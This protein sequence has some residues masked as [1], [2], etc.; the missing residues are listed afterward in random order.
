MENGVFNGETINFGSFSSSRHIDINEEE[1]YYNIGGTSNSLKSLKDEVGEKVG[2]LS[3][4]AK[5]IIS[6]NEVI[7]QSSGIYVFQELAP[8][9]TYVTLINVK[10]F[11]GRLPVMVVELKMGEGMRGLEDMRKRYS[12]D[13]ERVDE[14][15]REVMKIGEGF[16]GFLI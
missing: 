2:M 14:E 3:E 12:R 7:G 9:V 16:L 5:N 1:S 11:R 13:T 8:N 10:D 6:G 4:S 15:V